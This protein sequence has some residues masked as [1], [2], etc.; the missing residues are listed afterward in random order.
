MPVPRLVSSSCGTCVF[1][2]APQPVIAEEEELDAIYLDAD[3][4]LETVYQS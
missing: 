3:T 4:G 1:Y 2:Q